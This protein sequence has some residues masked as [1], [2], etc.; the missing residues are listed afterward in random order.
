LAGEEHEEKFLD[1]LIVEHR[2]V[3]NLQGVEKAGEQTLEGMR[4]RRGDLQARLEVGEFAGVEGALLFTGLTLP[5]EGSF[6]HAA[7][8]K[9]HD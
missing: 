3:L 6:S 7:L 5:A 4:V 9:G 8:P 2:D 1:Q